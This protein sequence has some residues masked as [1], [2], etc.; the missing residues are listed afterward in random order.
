MEESSYAASRLSRRPAQSL[1]PFKFESWHPVLAT[2]QPLSCAH[3]C[4]RAGKL[5][6]HARAR[7]A[8]LS[9][10]GERSDRK[11]KAPGLVRGDENPE[12]WG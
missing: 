9:E 6:T 4:N 1:T 2:A 3:S 8:E 11:E 10:G 12:R 5:I 7:T